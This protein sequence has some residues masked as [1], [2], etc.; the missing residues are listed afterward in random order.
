M[1]SLC[2]GTDDVANGAEMRR[3]CESLGALKSAV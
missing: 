2:V 1:F 3:E